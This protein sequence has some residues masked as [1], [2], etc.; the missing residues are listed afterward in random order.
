MRRLLILFVVIFVAVPT[1][2]QVPVFAATAPGIEGRI[3]GDD[4]ALSGANVQAIQSGAVIASDTTD[5]NGRYDL[6]LP[7]AGNYDVR[8]V[9]PPGASLAGTVAAGV[10]VGPSIVTVLDIQLRS[11][12][13]T[14]TI[15]VE[16]GSGAAVVGARVSLRG[17]GFTV[18]SATA[19]S[20]GVARLVSKP[21]SYGLRIEAPT[22]WTADS[23][24]PGGT[25]IDTGP[26]AVDVS[27]AG[28]ARTV[29]VPTATLTATTRRSD[30]TAVTG[31]LV[32]AVVSGATV[33]LGGGL[34]GTAR[35]A[36]TP[37]ASD[38]L[39]VVTHRVLAVPGVS[40][41]AT[42]PSTEPFLVAAS[43]TTDVPLAG[44]AVTVVLPP[45]PVQPVTVRFL[46]AAG[47]PV[48]D[49]T[50][51]STLATAS[52]DANGDATVLARSDVT[53]ELRVTKFSPDP[54]LP[55]A[56]TFR[57]N[58]RPLDPLTL[59]AQAKVGTVTVTVTRD[60]TTPLDEADVRVSA[61]AIV[62][63]DGW[64]VQ[65]PVVSKLTD[66]AGQATL[67]VYP[68][69]SANA[70]FSASWGQ[71]SGF[72]DA[73]IP[74]G[75]SSVTVDVELPDPP[76]TGTT[77]PVTGRVVTS[78][79]LP[80]AGL[81]VRSAA[82]GALLATTTA[83]GNFSFN[84]P[85]GPLPQSL[86]L[87][88]TNLHTR[89]NDFGAAVPVSL[90][91]VIPNVFTASSPS[92]VI[93]GDI[94]LPIDE[95]EV[96]VV[97]QA[98]G[99]LGGI[100]VATVSRDSRFPV[101]VGGSVIE[102][103]GRSDYPTTAF[104]N[105]FVLTELLGDVSLNLLPGTY[106]IQLVQDLSFS[107][108]TLPV[109][110]FASVDLDTDDIVQISL[111]RPN[112]ALLTS[113]DGTPKV[114]D[115]PLTLEGP[116]PSLIPIVARPDGFQ[117]GTT[118]TQGELLDWVLCETDDGISKVA[119]PR[120]S[121]PGDGQITIRLFDEE[122]CDIRDCARLPEF[123]AYPVTVR[124]AIQSSVDNDVTFL[125]DGWRAFEVT[126]LPP[127]DRA[128]SIT[129]GGEREVVGP[130]G[131]VTTFRA[132]ATDDN[133]G[134]EVS[135]DLDLDG[136][137]EVS[138]ETLLFDLPDGP[139]FGAINAIATDSSGQSTSTEVYWGSRNVAPDGVLQVSGPD[140][141][142][143]VSVAVVDITDPSADDL[144]AGIAVSLD[145]DRDGTFETPGPIGTI[146][147][148]GL[149]DGSYDVR[150]R[151]VD[152]DRGERI[153]TGSFRVGGP[154][155]NTAPTVDPGGPYAVDE[156]GTILLDASGDDSDGDPVTITWAVP[157]Q[158]TG[159]ADPVT[160][161]ATDLDGPTTVTVTVTAC[162]TPQSGDPECVDATVTV[163]VNNVAPS[164]TVDDVSSTAGTAV[165]LP[166]T[167]TDPAAADVLSV[168]V[169]W[170][171]GTTPDVITPYT[172]APVPHTYTTEG[173]FTVAVLAT[174]DDGGTTRA[175]A[176]ATIAAVP[177]PPPP[178]SPSVDLRL[179][180]QGG[181]GTVEPGDRF[182]Y[183]STVRNS[184][185]DADADGVVVTVVLDPKL[186]LDAPATTAFA[187]LVA[188][189]DPWTCSGTT[190]IRCSLTSPLN[191]GTDVT[192]DLPVVVA[193]GA[194]GRL[195]TTFSVSAATELAGPVSAERVTTV[196]EPID[197]ATPSTPTPVVPV[198]P[199]PAV[200]VEPSTPTAPIITTLPETGTDAGSWLAVALG[201]I[202]LGWVGVRTAHHGRAR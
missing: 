114:S 144:A 11:P 127:I 91:V 181:E 195:T 165:T 132:T 97:D 109:S 141:D 2:A 138:G 42:P 36:T 86:R 133:D 173:V 134:V 153:L 25:R 96:R 149:L 20:S 94:V 55:E 66:A 151:L 186:A 39:G 100:G 1:G 201:L 98:G 176:S 62:D 3:T 59:V 19:D 178:P 17:A 184:S 31:A 69:G 29:Q 199:S 111:T 48:V 71:L 175:T 140:G 45:T 35:F 32:G 67:R 129:I 163:T 143:T 6:D 200:P 18:T 23:L 80:I 126:I 104:G 142:G 168:S 113:L 193:A 115:D 63:A 61:P 197:D 40:V 106:E 26:G 103:R 76:G 194:S 116:R 196:T 28:E 53:T 160:F 74:D 147:T 95:L 102:A 77:V 162:D 172:G 78:G 169:D 38:A 112:A 119:V 156:G 4:S 30:G 49:A 52:T 166:L 157:G 131:S 15:T 92:G 183:R 121:C 60:L 146:D 57:R 22:P 37:I 152:R 85:T 84:Y 93:L 13:G 170:G 75:P 171:D 88:S 188:L 68:T 154:P 182:T 50:V 7:A 180:V 159:L 185:T 33:D 120:E 164:L 56:I 190:T 8:V 47:Q 150:A 46:D 105:A 118:S 125:R 130:E 65:S 90:Q 179:T 43:A 41:T 187:S 108:V 24:L 177:P 117:D 72:T 139:G 202:L 44:G 54:A 21:G 198:V 167:V 87:Q 191:A 64:V 192:L 79:N 27:V 14:L 148:T 81:Q 89:D 124:V 145:L 135:W 189:T 34:L 123:P 51:R 83:T 70:V 107:G 9:P 58:I 136:I 10:T 110:A 5:S 174:D 161:D 73:V 128:P 99:G 12:L 82:T 155:P 101:T 16:D 122:D 137:G 158:G